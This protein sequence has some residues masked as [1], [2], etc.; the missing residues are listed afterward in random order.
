MQSTRP[1]PAPRFSL[2]PLA[3][4]ALVLIAFALAVAWPAESRVFPEQWNL[5]LRTPID[6]LQ[7]WLINSR[8]ADHPVFVFG[9]EPF[10]AAVDWGL[11]RA[12]GLLLA[13]PWPAG[14]AL[15]GLL[16]WRLGGWRLAALATLSLLVMG[17]VG[18]WTASIQT[19][20]LMLVATVLTVAVGIPLGIAAALNDR[21]HRGLQPV[22]DTLQTM[23]TFVYLIPVVLL[24]GIARVPAVIATLLYALAPIV[25]LT[26]LGIRGVQPA[27]I[28][29]ARAFGSTRWQLLWK[30]QL[31][32]G[33]PAIMT[34]VNQTIMMAMSMVVIAALIGAGGLGREVLQAMQ[35]V[36]VGAAFEAG[37]AI[38]LL[39][40]TLDR[41][42]GRLASDRGAPSA[43]RALW[44]ALIG[45]AALAWVAGGLGVVAFP[46]AWRVPVRA[47]VDAVVVWMRDNLFE[48]PFGPWVLGSGPLSD[49]L[50]LSVLNPFRDLLTK[51]LPWPSV[52]LLFAAAA[53]AA[54]GWRPAVLTALLVV[55]IGLFGMWAL[56]MDTLSQVIVTLLLTALLAV[57]LG[58]WMSQ[59]DRARAL[60]TPLLDFLQTVP[61]FVLLVPVIMLFNVGRVPGIIAAVLYAVAPGAR[62]TDLGIRGVS[63]ESIEASRAFGSTQAQTLT[64]VQLPLALPAILAGVNQMVMMVLAM[65]IIAGLVG[66]AG[67]G[68]EVVTGVSRNQPG[69][70][71]EAGLAIV[72][73]AIVLDRLS[74]ALA[75]RTDE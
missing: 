22:L 74:Q 66:G 29:A 73:L 23:P 12:E 62:L 28:E 55:T 69:R 15:A 1:L 70:A 46:E 40:I 11:R 50:T 17:L 37:L 8:A 27:A 53:W 71:A 39:A 31:P 45:V 59:S 4:A 2:T 14:L 6:A 44:M 63:P 65:V 5:G 10:S 60:I 24:F 56:A 21:V 72:L 54:K 20:A 16:G 51:V 33:L 18:L 75:Q 42:S 36:Q 47:P 68:L 35:R 3:P 26:D 32:L 52:V 48:F 41:M 19:L 9:F 38:V 30:V 58:I 34:G 57:P 67:L 13:I 25:R 64:K 7:R 61:S 49:W 43:D